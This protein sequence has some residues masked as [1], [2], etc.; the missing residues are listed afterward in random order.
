MITRSR[1]AMTNQR[2]VNQPVTSRQC[3]IA[4][5]DNSEQLVN[6]CCQNCEDKKFCQKH[7]MCMSCY[8]NLLRNACEN[9]RNPV[10]PLDRSELAIDP[11][12]KRMVET[13]VLLD[14]FWANL[15]RA[16]AEFAQIRASSTPIRISERRTVRRIRRQNAVTVTYSPATTPPGVTN[17]REAMDAEQSPAPTPSVVDGVG[18]VS[19][20]DLNNFSGEAQERAFIERQR[21]EIPIEQVRFPFWTDDEE[22]TFLYENQENIP[23][24]R[25]V[26]DEAANGFHDPN[27]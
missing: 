18:P 2:P 27:A 16:A 3:S 23:P 25:D 1:K 17:I 19:V 24:F 15:D 6:I 5:C 7:Y 12:M 22:L 20:I 4:F 21:Y 26:D 13:D 9:K 8:V 10:C 11:M 14:G